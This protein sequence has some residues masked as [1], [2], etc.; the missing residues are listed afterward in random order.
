M[1]IVRILRRVS[2]SWERRN[3]FLSRIGTTHHDEEGMGKDTE[4]KGKKDRSKK[5]RRGKKQIWRSR[6]P[7][8]RVALIP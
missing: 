1:N 6:A 4:E 5:G 7:L 8:K 2:K 3:F